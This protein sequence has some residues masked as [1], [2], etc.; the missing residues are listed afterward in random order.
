MTTVRILP[1]PSALTPFEAARLR[2][3]LRAVDGGVSGVC[4]SYVYVLLL[5]EGWVDYARL[6]E[7]LGAGEG[8]AAGACVWI[9]PRLGTQSPWSSKATDILHHTGFENIAGSNGRAWFALRVRMMFGPSPRPC[10]TA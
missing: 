7:L 5:R 6:G 9:A 10:T 4:A 8:P 2:E 1:G 3:R